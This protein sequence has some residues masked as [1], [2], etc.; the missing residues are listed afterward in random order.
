[1]AFFLHNTQHPQ[2]RNE[3]V[4][5]SDIENLTPHSTSNIHRADR[6]IFLQ[7]FQE[8]ML[9]LLRIFR[10]RLPYRQVVRRTIEFDDDGDDENGDAHTFYITIKPSRSSS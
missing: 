9:T 6:R 5:N 4:D 1:M 10:Q 7:N 2:D 3:T 8:E